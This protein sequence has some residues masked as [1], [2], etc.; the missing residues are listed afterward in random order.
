MARVFEQFGVVFVKKAGAQALAEE[1]PW[2]GGDRCSVN[3]TTG[4][5]QCFK[6]QA[7]GNVTTFL[8][9]AHGERLAR[10]TA[11]HRGRLARARGVAPQTLARH[12]L[13]YDEAARR[14]LVPFRNAQG[15]IATMQLYYPGRP[16]PNK[17]MLPVLPTALYGFDKLAAPDKAK[18][19][20]LCEGPWDALALD[21]ALGLHRSRYVITATPGFF[22][23]VWAQHFRGRK[24]R[25]LN[26]NDDGGRKQAQRVQTLLGERGV[27]AE[28]LVLRWPD[29][30]PDGYDLNDWVREHGG[31]G[32][33][34][35]VTENSYKVVP[36]PRLAW[37]FGWD[38]KAAAPEVIDW[39]WPDHLRCGSYASLSGRGG[40]FK[41][42]IAREV[43][44][45]YTRGRPMPLCDRVGLPAGYVI[46]ITAEDS[47]AN[48]WTK[49][50]QAGA[51]AEKVMVLPATTKDGGPMNILEHFEELRQRVREK[52][53]RLV[54]LDGQNSVVG[55]P[56]I[57]TDMLARNNVTGPLHRF[58]Q[59]ENICLLGI[60][61][62]DQDGRAYGP[63]SMGDIAR[64]ILR[65]EERKSLGK[66]RYFL[67]K[68][69]KVTDAPRHTHPDIPYCVP[70]LD[71]APP[72]SPPRI[73]WG[74][75]RPTDDIPAHGKLAAGAQLRAA[76]PVPVSREK[77]LAAVGKLKVGLKKRA[78]P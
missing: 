65:V 14:W 30:T 35:F 29:G 4:Q 39:V 78:Q 37:E 25:V 60:R 11:E 27:A 68:F 48:A 50:E 62:E 77:A 23:E 73:R 5:Y 8:D 41:S 63:A 43:V 33:V 10:T 64:C 51:D 71:S 52:G 2:C 76:H 20:F 67:L 58:A 15:N 13:A 72:G 28:V 66:D 44:A 59:R 32:V 12:D 56:N 53:V 75:G 47:P 3:A 70:A 6:C 61:N 21:Y 40:T 7:R 22:K 18:P 36:A 17:L 19:V 54:V 34:G 57:S 31:R 45:R 69:A 38:R 49:L 24:V 1:C 55:A 26:D 42:T 9:W 74:K 46:Y 16:R